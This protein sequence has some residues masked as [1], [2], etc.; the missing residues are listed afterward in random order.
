MAM[1][2]RKREERIKKFIIYLLIFAGCVIFA[3][4]FVWMIVTAIKEDKQIFKYPPEWIPKTYEVTLKGKLKYG[5]GFENWRKDIEEKEKQLKDR[6]LRLR[7][8]RPWIGELHI[9]VFL[10]NNIEEYVFKRWM[11]KEYGKNY[12]RFEAGEIY[13]VEKVEKL[14]KIC[15]KRKL[16]VIKIKGIITAGDASYSIE[17]KDLILSLKYRIRIFWEN[18][19]DVFREQPFFFRFIFN[20][21][22][23]TFINII[24]C[25]F[26][27]SL[28]AFS[29]SRL[30]WP[31]RDTVFLVLLG[32]MMIPIPVTMVPVFLIYRHL[33]L[34]NTLTPLWLGSLFGNAFFIFMLRQFFLTIPRDLED[35]AKI[36]GC[37]YFQIYWQ[38]FLPLTK[39]ALATVAIWQFMWSWNDFLGPLIYINTKEKMTLALGLQVFQSTH[40]GD[41]ALMMAASFMMTLPVILLFFFFQRYFIQG[42]TLTGLKS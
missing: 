23:V 34:V 4:P 24:L 13:P 6:K 32:T 14:R 38:I 3:M 12:I 17:G 36:D 8:T 11:I 2:K 25:T 26:M 9:S 30:N 20:S 16:K 10:N 35:A 33:G 31:G 15:K 27:S 39:P 28:V 21:L 19:V 41:F 37:N 7:S 42:I 5:K 1:V 40:G 18:F 29:F 22:I